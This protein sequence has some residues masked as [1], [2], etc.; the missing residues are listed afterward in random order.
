[1]GD[2]R[3]EA[4]LI[5][6]YG[7]I[8]SGDRDAVEG[9]CRRIVD[10]V[11]LEMTATQFAITWGEHFFATVEQSNHAA[12]QTLFEC[13]TASLRAT[14][15]ALGLA[16]DPGPFVA[17]LEDYWRNPPVYDDAV[18]FLR[19]IELPVCCV[20][21]ADTEPLL[22][23]IEKHGLPFNAVISSQ[24]AR[25]YKPD[26]GIF[27]RA[28]AAM[29]V[30]PGRVVHIGDSLHSDIAG[31]SAAGIAGVW[32]RRENRIHDIGTAKPDFTVSG[33]SELHT[34]LD[35]AIRG[36]WQENPMGRPPDEFRV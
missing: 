19:D 12:F 2:E 24:D 7:T 28:L 23:A 30:G 34:I 26:P 1:M 35:G 8:C 14:F 33:L 31:A 5:D 10:S 4:V 21:N 32:V 27:E 18:A 20:S 16:S 29:K 17:E 15:D 13:E 3:L 22:A 36:A 11:G 6:F 9:V 25:C